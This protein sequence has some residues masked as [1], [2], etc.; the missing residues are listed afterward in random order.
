MV[1]LGMLPASFLEGA[2]RARA[3]A[4]GR[5]DNRGVIQGC[6]GSPTFETE[7]TS[8]ECQAHYLMMEAAYEALEL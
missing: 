3:F 5:V 6:A 8:A 7:G 1:S 4:V 2:L